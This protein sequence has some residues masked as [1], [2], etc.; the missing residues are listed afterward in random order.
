MKYS[1]TGYKDNSLDKDESSLIIPG[2]HITMKGVSRQLVLVP[3]VNGNP[4]YNRKVVANP[5]DDDII[6]EEDVEGVMEMPYSQ[7]GAQL[8]RY[9]SPYIQNFVDNQQQGIPPMINVNPPTLDEYANMG[10]TPSNPTATLYDQSL[11]NQSLS[12]NTL[13]VG[14]ENLRQKSMAN[15]TDTDIDKAKD[16]KNE[17][18]IGAFNPYGGWNMHSASQA[19]GAFAQD[20]NILGTVG[21]AGKLVL[22]GARN[23]M[24][25]AAGMKRFNETRNE[26]EDKIN[27]K[28]RERGWKWLRDG[29]T[30]GKLLTGNYIEGNDDHSSPNVEVEKKEYLQTPDGSTMEVL[31]KKHSEG[32]ELLNMPE[33][34][35][36]ISDYLKIGSKL[37]SYFKKEFGLNAKSSNSFATIM[38]MYRKKIG[39]TELIDDEE[40]LM[41]KIIKQDNVEFEGTRELNLQVLSE[42]VNEIKPKKEALE[43]KFEVFTNL[44]FD[45][46]EESKQDG[47][48]NFNKQEG[49]EIV[50]PQPEMDQSSQE[51]TSEI[52]QI[53][54]AFSQITG[55]DPSMIIQQLQQLPENEIESALQ[56][57]MQVVQQGAPSQED[58]NLEQQV[59]QEEP[60]AFMQKAGVIGRK[61]WEDYKEKYTFDPTY[62][63]E[64]RLKNASKIIPFL[65]RFGIKYSDSDLSTEEGLDRLAGLAQNAARKQYSNLTNHYSSV[66]APTQA[67]LQTALDNKLISESELKSLGVKTNKG[68]ILR[69]SKNIVPKG[70]E[71]KV[72]DIITKNGKENPDGYNKYV[73]TNF[74]DNKWYFRNPDIQKVRFDTQQELDDYVKQHDVSFDDNNEKIYY[75]NKEGLY[76]TPIVGDN[77]TTS[78]NPNPTN[79]SG[80]IL[81]NQE[82][83]NPSG[84]ID[85]LGNLDN[86]WDTGLP[87]SL[88]DQ[89]NLPPNLLQPGLRQL[90]HV[91]A[92][93][94][95]VSPEETIKELNRQYNTASNLIAETNPYTTGAMMANLQA[96]TNNSTN[97]AYSQAAITNAQDERNVENINEER[98]QQR[99]VYNTGAI[100][101]FEQLSQTA[102]QNYYDEWRGYI[103]KKN[104]E[105]LNNYN[106]E[107]QRQGFNA[108]NDN[109]KIGSLGWYQ[110]GESPIFYANGKAMMEDPKTGDIYELTKKADTKGNNSVT[111]T[112]GKYRNTKSSRGTRTRGQKGG[113]LLSKDN[114]KKWLK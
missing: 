18:F 29:G 76:F 52:E 97:Q 78:P 63:F 39:L 98:I 17:D 77:P 54:L 7:M 99:D 64:D 69:G 66:V 61:E 105:N 23:V 106:T 94:I 57:M 43:S 91:Q 71:N 68:K 108:V 46:Q 33:G 88:P 26:Y 8:G 38:N 73:D 37:A 86:E 62:G 80:N 9:T 81:A 31:G 89:S 113:L 74:V 1:T 28:E 12:N 10:L 67:G 102:L 41:N 6:F 3:I 72:R 15:S 111:E 27:R 70:N 50:E 83:T 101:N 32:G 65:N 49:G 60:T 11:Y 2:R 75:S 85:K 95:R 79:P 96:Q 103:D 34:T 114:L 104:L 90:G 44:V 13:N 93:V 55:Q 53:I 24:A 25:G 20:K 109:Y 5:G 16:K 56:Q 48:Y 36:V 92:N 87:M 42:K 110:T 21:A 58:P 107:M 47:G 45:K 19:L 22:E 84:D 35:K 14:D 112:T 59:Q 4:D 100:N 40:K 82:K 51:G 30:T